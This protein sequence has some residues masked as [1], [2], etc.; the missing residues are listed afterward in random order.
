[1]KRLKE[2]GVAKVDIERSREQLIITIHAM[3]PG[4]I[5]GRAGSGIEDLKKEII[6]KFINK[7]QT[8]V[9][10]KVSVSISVQEVQNPNLNSQIVLDSMIADLEKR[11]AYRRVMKQAV[12]RV[13]RAGALGVKVIVAGRLNGAEIART[14]KL[15]VGRLPLHTLR[16]DIDYARGAAQTMYGK[17]GVKVWIYRGDVFNKDMDAKGSVVSKPSSN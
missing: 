14:E 7:E 3:K 15:S 5:I 16:A 6:T 13:D 1:M 17:I 2:S 12:G 8:R 10:G 4:V 11:I 9:P